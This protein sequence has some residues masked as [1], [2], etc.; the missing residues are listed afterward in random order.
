MT[1]RDRYQAEQEPEGVHPR[2]VL[3]VVVIGT[4]V[5]GA[6]VAVSWWL[7]PGDPPLGEAPA[8][9]ETEREEVGE[10]FITD[11][12]ARGRGLEL[13]DEGRKHLQRYGWVDREEGVA[14]I[15]IDVAMNLYLQRHTHPTHEKPPEV[16]P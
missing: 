16:E 8:E 15:P 7:L 14:F 12:N 2:T 5:A 3:L 13:Q 4:L 9:L 1:H 10:V 11:L 6:T